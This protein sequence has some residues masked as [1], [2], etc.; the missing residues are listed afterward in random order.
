MGQQHGFSTA[1]RVVSV[2]GSNQY[3]DQWIRLR[4]R[5]NLRPSWF[6]FDCF[7]DSESYSQRNSDPDICNVNRIFRHQY[8]IDD[9]RLHLRAIFNTR[10][11][12]SADRHQLYD[13]R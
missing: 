1:A 12:Y 13:H 5:N 4:D 8:S 10:D 7:S 2:T 3:N 9:E 11:I 6:Q